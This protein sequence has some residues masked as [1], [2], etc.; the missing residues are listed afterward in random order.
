MR[1]PEELKGNVITVANFITPLLHWIPRGIPEYT[2]HG[3]LHTRNVL[4]YVRDLVTEYSVEFFDEEKY[5][6]ALSAVL[7]DIGCIAGKEE[8]NRRSIEILSMPQFEFFR[9]LIGPMFYR[10]LEQIIISHSKNYDLS[11]IHA[12]PSPEIRLK[13]I[14]SIFRLADACDISALR[15]KQ[16]VFDVLVKEEKLE[17]KSI[18]IWRSHLEIENIL[19]IG[20]RIK[21]N[22]YDLDLAKFCLNNLE[23][24]IESINPILTEMGLPVFELDSEKVEKSIIK[25]P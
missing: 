10:A 11:Q 21:A 13:F 15:V 14:S 25:F 22:V 16:L 5:L 6:L 20:N 19:I 1:L 7:H 24:E 8:H 12:D 9:I 23:E 18:D 17:K 2:D 4:R 3:V